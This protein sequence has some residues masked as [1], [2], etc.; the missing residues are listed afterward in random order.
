MC[1]GGGDGYFLLGG[2]ILAFD[3]KFG[4]IFFKNIVLFLN[5]VLEKCRQDPSNRLKA[6]KSQVS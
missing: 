3:F 2:S 1:G 4:Y 6:T 5:K